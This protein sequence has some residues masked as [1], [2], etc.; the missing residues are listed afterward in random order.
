MAE[1]TR[2]SQTSQDCADTVDR[3]LRFKFDSSN[4]A[5]HQNPWPY[6]KSLLAGPPIFVERRGIQWAVVSR[7]S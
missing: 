6:F 4:P 5:I 1:D 2:L 7:Y 3:D